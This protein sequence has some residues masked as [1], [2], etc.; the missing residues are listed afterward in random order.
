[1]ALNG[2]TLGQLMKAQCLSKGLKGT[3]IAPFCLAM[4]EGVVTSFVQM[5]KVQTMDVGVLT[6]GVGKGKMLGLLPQPLL[7]AAV[8]LMLSQG[9]KGTKSKDFMEALCN[10]T[11]LHFNAMNEVSTTHTTVA[12]GT[13]IGKVLGLTPNS[14]VS[15][16]KSKM[17]A[18]NIKGEKLEPLVKAYCTA[19][20]NVVM[21]TTT[22]QVTI[23][24]VPAPLVVLVPIPSV[25]SGQGKVT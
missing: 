22:V 20:C 23:T 19:F 4:G 13:G 7:Q 14:M 15:L 18:K 17:A 12:L 10:A 9:L 1:M 2:S 3:M 21:S 11:A 8:P 24:G 16:I 6:V 5:N 25:G